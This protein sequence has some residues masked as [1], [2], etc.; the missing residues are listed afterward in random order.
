MY[1]NSSHINKQI[2]RYGELVSIEDFSSQTYSDYGDLVTQTTS[3]SSVKAIFNTYGNSSVYNPETNFD[4]IR[5]SFFF[6]GSQTGVETD[7][8]V[9]RA[10][11]ERWKI[12]KTLNHS[13]SGETIVQESMV[14]N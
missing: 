1:I 3:T 11:G 5:Y 6:K 4:E 12:T 13:L 2:D 10:N 8:I 7:N 9:V 14:T